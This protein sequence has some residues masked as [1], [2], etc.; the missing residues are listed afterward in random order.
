MCMHPSSGKSFLAGIS[1]SEAG[2]GRGPVVGNHLARMDVVG[3]H[4]TPVWLPPLLWVRRGPRRTFGGELAQNQPS[5]GGGKERAGWTVEGRLMW[6]WARPGRW[7]NSSEEIRAGEGEW[8]VK[9]T[10]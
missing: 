9:E 1:G 3:Q 6:E 8:E 10:V 4:I 2:T 5:S 7:S